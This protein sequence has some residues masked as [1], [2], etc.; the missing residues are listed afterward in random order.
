MF[1]V[2]DMHANAFKVK[3]IYLDKLFN[4]KLEEKVKGKQ[5]VETVNL[6]INFESLYNAVR[7][8]HVEKYIMAANKKEL[9]HAYRCMIS[10]FINVAAHY[11]KYFTNKHIKTRIFFYYNEIP[12]KLDDMMY[13]N[14]S[15]IPEYRHHF[16]KSINRMDRVVINSIIQESIQFMKIITEYIDDVFMIGT[17]ALE[18]SLVPMV[19]DMENKHPANVNIVISR[20]MYDLQYVNKNWLVISKFKDQ[21]ILITK[22]N[23]IKYLRFRNKY[24]KLNRIVHPHLLTFILSCLG[25]RKRGIPGVKGFGFTKTYRA[26]CELY[27]LGYLN[28]EDV[29]TME[30][31]NLTHVMNTN[32]IKLFKAEDLATELMRSYR[33]TDLDMQYKF[34]SDIQRERIFDQLINKIDPD[35]LVDINE[36]YF[37]DYPLMLMELNNYNRALSIIPK[38]I[39]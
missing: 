36:T 22:R 14:S 19:I 35:A 25:D 30:I 2:I 23:V 7:N 34:V 33:V 32:E 21:P 28:D 6:Y 11:R 1:D 38:E 37:T 17:N 15:M 9:N 29:D 8:R 13:N 10:N 27:D 26:L 5:V 4:G 16:F 12:E 18:S 39:L 31:A 20:D 3:Y 24:D